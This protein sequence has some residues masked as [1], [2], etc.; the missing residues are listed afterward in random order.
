MTDRNNEPN[1]DECCECP[2]APD[3]REF[4][5]QATLAAIGALVAAGMPSALAA[6]TVPRLVSPR[7]RIGSNPTYP[8]PAEDGVQ[9]DTANEIILVRWQ[10]AVYAFNL[11]CPHQ[12]VALRWNQ[13][14]TQFQC[15]K[16]HSKYQP[17]G[18]FVSGRA[19]RNMDRFSVSRAGNE[20]L[21]NVDSMHKSDADTAGWTASVI[22]LP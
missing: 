12:K 17:D 11:A 2:L 14:D 13:G 6:A 9:I 16:H 5:K 21:V 1:L 3:R 20:I 10:N 15:P 7:Y 8:I 18:T 22:H 19:T 4:L